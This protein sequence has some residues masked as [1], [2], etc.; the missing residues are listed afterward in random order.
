ML[1][2]KDSVMAKRNYVTT[3]R[4][5]YYNDDEIGSISIK[6]V[7][8]CLTCNNYGFK[9]QMPTKAELKAALEKIKKDWLE[10]VSEDF[11]FYAHYVIPK[12]LEVSK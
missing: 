5:Y 9:K 12:F 7:L 3:E 8:L 4:D 2:Y 10:T 11:D 1:S 6:D